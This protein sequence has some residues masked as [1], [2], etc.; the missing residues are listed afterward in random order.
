MNIHLIS[1]GG[2]VMHNFAL[3]LAQHGHHVTGSDD[4]I[5][6]PSKTRL[7]EQGLLPKQMGWDA[8]SVS[9]KIDIVILGMHAREDN[10]ELLKAKELNIPIYSFPAYTFEQAQNQ[11]R[12]VVAGSHGKTTT[13]G[14]LMHVF[15]TLKK[16]FDYLVGSQLDGYERMVQFSDAPVILI[17]G[18]EYL[19]SALD[20]RPKFLHY[21][22]QLAMITGIAWDHINVFPT[23]A[24]YVEQFELFIKSMPA[25]STCFYNDLDADLKQLCERLGDKVDAELKPYGLLAYKTID[26]GIEILFESESYAMPWFGK[27]NVSNMTGAML[28]AAQ[29]GISNKDFIKSMQHFGGT[30]RRLENIYEANG[31][32]VIRDFAHSPSKLAAT[33]AAVKEQY[34]SKNVIAVF[35]L[36]TYSSLQSNF[37][38]HYKNT[39]EKADKSIVYIDNHVFEIKR[40]EP[41]SK[42]EIQDGFVSVVEVI[43]NKI[44]LIKS[45]KEETLTNTVLLLMSS[46]SFSGMKVEDLL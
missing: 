33:T 27:H 41:L 36:H 43:D 29:Y 22:P 40:M 17:E 38:P 7:A 4:D 32:T 24:N 30:A 12:I 28:M 20:R 37:L 16:D 5:F 42:Q 34:N 23:Y 26:N 9:P 21:K 10:P 44:D 25:G 39:M 2:A 19:S 18:D 3:A 45:I 11:Q 13:T 46:G 15:E 14:M 31:L 6:E 35:E 1:I 8:N